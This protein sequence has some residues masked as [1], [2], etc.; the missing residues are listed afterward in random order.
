MLL[1]WPKLQAPGDIA[2]KKAMVKPNLKPSLD[3]SNDETSP[4]LINADSDDIET[5]KKQDVKF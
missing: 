1:S 4:L 2:K 3:D 5:W